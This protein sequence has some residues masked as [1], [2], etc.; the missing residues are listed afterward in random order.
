MMSD[1]KRIDVGARMSQAVVHGNTVYTAGQVA[2]RAPGAS[3]ADQTKDILA[4]ID[5]LLA[6]AGTSKEKLLIATIWL[7]DMAGFNEMN[8]V[9]DA[10]VVPGATPGR[11]CVESKL[12]APQFT[13]EIQ[14]IAAL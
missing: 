3:V 4:R 7:S 14:V 5:E 1:I 8:E 11:A 13:V 6:E 10:W 2:L 12:A 9:W